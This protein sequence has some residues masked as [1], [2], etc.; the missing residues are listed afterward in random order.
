MEQ[1]ESEAVSTLEAT[2]AEG[3][4]TDKEKQRGKLRYFQSYLA[5]ER[6]KRKLAAEAA[7][8]GSP[9]ATLAAQAR[10]D[11]WNPDPTF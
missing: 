8:A 4:W 9:P 5:E 11:G 7:A 1:R 2:F 10:H 3:K 6:K